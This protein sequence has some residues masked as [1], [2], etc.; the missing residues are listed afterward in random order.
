DFCVWWGF[1]LIALAAGGWWSVISPLAMSFLLLKV[2]GVAMLEKTIK[3][4]RPDYSDYLQSTN[5]FFPGPGKAH[6]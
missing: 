3:E 4:R 6:H 2:S 1:F 5:A